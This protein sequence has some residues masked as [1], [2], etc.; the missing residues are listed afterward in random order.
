VQ[1]T[2]GASAV[3][4][5]TGVQIIVVALAVGLGLA[6]G[7]V[8]DRPELRWLAIVVLAGVPV[9]LLILQLRPA[10]LA[11]RRLLAP[12]F[13]A[14]VIGTLEVG[15]ARL[16]HMSVLIAGHWL[17]MRLFGI[18]VPMAAAVTR[19]PVL[20]LVGALPISP[21]GLGTTQAAAVTLFSEY[22][23]GATPEATVLAYSLSFQ[24]IGTAIAA[25]WGLA[26]LRWVTARDD[27]DQAGS[28]P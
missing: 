2:E 26:C 16:A 1:I 25:A 23:E 5:A 27:L 24:V 9:Y 6:L 4:L 3:L 13:D 22:A 14:G 15:L 8:P 11:S 21:S 19:L 20:F 18:E 12:L 10:A 28:A 7:A 17:A